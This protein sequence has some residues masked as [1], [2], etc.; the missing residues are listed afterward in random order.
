[1]RTI[2]P[3][4]VVTFC[5]SK[6]VVPVRNGESAVFVLGDQR[7]QVL[8]AR[9]GWSNKCLAVKCCVW[10]SDNDS[11]RGDAEDECRAPEEDDGEQRGVLHTAYHVNLSA[12][13]AIRQR[14]NPVNTGQR[15]VRKI[16]VVVV[17]DDVR[18][19]TCRLPKVHYSVSCTKG[20]VAVEVVSLPESSLRI[21]RDKCQSL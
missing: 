18:F 19:E 7:S 6:I 15:R 4:Q 9:V 14:C 10:V 11:G 5:G 16:A 20:T 8:R 1:M 12:S 21:P 2:K 17:H 13:F 3:G